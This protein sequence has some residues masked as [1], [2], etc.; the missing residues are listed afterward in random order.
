MTSFTD[1]KGYTTSYTYGVHNQLHEVKDQE[2]NVISK[3]EY[4]Y[5]T[6]TN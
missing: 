6:P 2:R 5:Q 4:S 3:N 1:A